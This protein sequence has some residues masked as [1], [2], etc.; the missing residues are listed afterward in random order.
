MKK[1]KIKKEIAVTLSVLLAITILVFVVMLLFN[2]TD[3]GITIA[4][5]GATVFMILSRP[6]LSKKK[7]FGAY[8]VSTLMGYV[9]VRFSISQSADVALA[10]VSSVVIM[11]ILEFQHAPAIGMSVAMVLNRFPFWVDLVVLLCI[12]SIIGMTLLL[13]KFIQQPDKFINFIEI[14]EEKIK[15]NLKKRKSIEYINIR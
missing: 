15:W 14:E 4:S 11:T 7:I 13:K 5:F 9:F 2:V 8:F 10:A 6:K 3:Y 1:P 12:F